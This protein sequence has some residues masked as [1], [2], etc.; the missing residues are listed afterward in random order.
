MIIF[1]KS[2]IWIIFALI[3]V[4]RHEYDLAQLRV[5]KW[6]TRNWAY[7]IA[8]NLRLFIYHQLDVSAQ[9]MSLDCKTKKFVSGLFFDPTTSF[10]FFR[11]T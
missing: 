1:L 5:S 4:L 9:L 6:L 10:N 3:R 8:E 2:Y 7:E 11:N